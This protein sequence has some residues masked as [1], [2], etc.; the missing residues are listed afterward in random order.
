M[1]NRPDI[2]S[3]IPP[4]LRNKYVITLLVFLLWITVFD[5]ES[6]V[7]WFN[8]RV[9]IRRMKTEKQYYRRQLKS[10]MDAMQHLRSNNDSL[11]KFAREHY[12]F[13]KPDEDVFVVE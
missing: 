12:G 7:S 13:H 4:F 10:T 1:V 8:S 6:L 3:K 5:K 11:E 2:K 9:E